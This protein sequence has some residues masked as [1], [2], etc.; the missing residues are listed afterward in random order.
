MNISKLMNIRILNGGI[1]VEKSMT[2]G[3]CRTVNGGRTM[4]KSVIV[5]KR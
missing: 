1:P 3:R 4:K 2:M 5:Y